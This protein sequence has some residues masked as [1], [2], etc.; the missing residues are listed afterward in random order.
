MCNYKGLSQ[1]LYFDLCTGIG[2]STPKVKWEGS[3]VSN[4]AINNNERIDSRSFYTFSI[5][6][7][8]SKSFYLK[9]EIGT[10]SIENRLD[11]QFQNTK[12]S[13]LYHADFFY[14]AIL[15]E[16]RFFKN[17]F[18]YVNIGYASYQSV[19]NSLTGINS[20]TAEDF[21]GDASRGYIFNIGVNPKFKM[22]GFIFNLGL[23][24]VNG[25]SRDTKITPTLG[26]LQS[27]FKVGVSYQ[28][29]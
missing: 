2:S 28:L 21:R 11:F 3:S 14:W 1:K 18:L 8:L 25:T 24:I 29:E 10:N 12:I 20:K 22:I 9:T 23:H 19:S 17:D 4:N 5:T 7:Q 27:N 15:P 16:V 26:F 6:G 13:G